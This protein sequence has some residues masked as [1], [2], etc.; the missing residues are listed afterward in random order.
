MEGSHT[1]EEDTGRKTPRG[2]GGPAS[3]IRLDFR[4]PPRYPPARS[5]VVV[6]PVTHAAG[7]VGNG[8]RPSQIPPPGGTTSE[9][10][11]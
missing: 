9:P 6:R 8:S 2:C 7:H 1:V 3:I 11:S 10:A 4:S 5:G